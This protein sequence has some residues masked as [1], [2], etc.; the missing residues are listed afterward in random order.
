MP[1]A[2]TRMRRRTCHADADIYAAAMPLLRAA[3]AC[4]AD[5]YFTPMMMTHY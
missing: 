2:M 3:Y 1:H 4:H 5:D